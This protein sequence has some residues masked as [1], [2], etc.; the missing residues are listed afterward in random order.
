MEKRQTICHFGGTKCRNPRNTYFSGMF[1][2][3]GKPTKQKIMLLKPREKRRNTHS[4]LSLM[5]KM[6]H[7][8]R[9]TVL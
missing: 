9:N 6:V 7:I 8:K 1:T 4:M 5:I 2:S 3:E